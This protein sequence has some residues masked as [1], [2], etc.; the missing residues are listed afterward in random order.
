M[1]PRSD[2]ETEH[3]QEQMSASA[4]ADVRVISLRDQRLDSRELFIGTREI[5]IDHGG[6]LYRLRLTQQNKLILTK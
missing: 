4:D 2:L 1:P 5:I 6:E 3:R